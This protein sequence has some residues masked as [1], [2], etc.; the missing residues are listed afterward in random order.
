MVI[1]LIWNHKVIITK[2]KI[3]NKIYYNTAIQRSDRMLDSVNL[4]VHK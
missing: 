4:Q 3:Y 2:S 1:N